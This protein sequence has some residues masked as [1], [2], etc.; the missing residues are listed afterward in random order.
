MSPLPENRDAYQ[1]LGQLGQTDAS[2]I[3]SPVSEELFDQLTDA[4]ERVKKQPPEKAHTSFL[5]QTLYATIDQTTGYFFL[6]LA[7]R[8][9]LG[10]WANRVVNV[11]LRTTRG[12]LHLIVTQVLKELDHQQLHPLV[13]FLGQ[14]LIPLHGKAFLA[15]PIAPELAQ[16]LEQAIELA[17]HSDNPVEQGAFIAETILEVSDVGMDFHFKEILRRIQ[18]ETWIIHSV[19][20]GLKISKKAVRTMFNKVIPTLEKPQLIEM[21]SFMEENFLRGE[22]T[23]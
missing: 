3:L 21:V 7:T 11:G 9:N 15:F 5:K 23:R 22:Q 14:T 17:R 19:N 12:G 20:F 1:K 10:K 2:F 8:M 6:G 16:R 4:F 13:D 18:V